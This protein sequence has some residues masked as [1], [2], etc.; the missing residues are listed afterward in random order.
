[1]Y[2]LCIKGT[3][4]P[5][6][7]PFTTREQAEAKLKLFESKQLEIVEQIAGGPPIAVKGEKK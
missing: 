6:D 4:I 5:I 3:R 1:M 7:G 2:A